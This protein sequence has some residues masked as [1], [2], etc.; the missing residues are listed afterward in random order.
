MKKDYL[1]L[2]VPLFAFVLM[3]TGFAQSPVINELYSRGIATEPDWIEIYNPTSTSIDITGY[4]IYDSGGN[5][6]TKPKKEF[7]T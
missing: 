5:A 3:Q 6:G 4:K 1:L 2:F 7:P